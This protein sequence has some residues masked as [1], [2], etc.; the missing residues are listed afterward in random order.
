[1]KYRITI[2]AI[3]R[4]EASALNLHDFSLTKGM[5]VEYYKIENVI[6]GHVVQLLNSTSQAVIQYED[7][8]ITTVNPLLKL[9]SS[10]PFSW[11]VENGYTV[12]GLL[13]SESMSF[14]IEI[15]WNKPQIEYY[16]CRVFPVGNLIIDDKS[17]NM[18]AR[19]NSTLKAVF[20]EMDNENQSSKLH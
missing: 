20:G 4:I 14:K 8:F 7:D 10:A 16:I 18:L 17:I 15:K 3:S 6:C 19:L 1:M 5:I 9:I 12:Y 13:I 2:G 11:G